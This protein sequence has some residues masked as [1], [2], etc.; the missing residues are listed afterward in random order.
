MSVSGSPKKW[1]E[2]PTTT[3][4]E[5]DPE[6]QRISDLGVLVRVAQTL[7]QV[8]GHDI[9]AM[10]PAQVDEYKEKALAWLKS[11]GPMGPSTP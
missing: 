11:R 2:Q 5:T 8:D 3:I 10:T 6:T 9:R 4:V 1:M 7:A